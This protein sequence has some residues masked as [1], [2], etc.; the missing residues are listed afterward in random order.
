MSNS[1]RHFTIDRDARGVATVWVDVQGLPVNVFSD[2]V[3]IELAQLV[4]DLERQLPRLAVFRG[5]KKSGFLVGADVRRIHTID[6][7]DDARF[8][9]TAGQQLFQRFAQ[10]PFPTVAV[11]HGACLGGGLEFAL[12]FRFRVARDDS[13]TRLGLPETLLGLCPAWGGTQRLP[14]LVGVR[15]AVRMIL[16][17]SKLT[18][19]QAADAGLVDLAAPPETFEPMLE[20]FVADRLAG[21]P[22]PSR[23]RGLAGRFLDGTAAGRRLVLRAARRAIACRGRHYPALAAALTAIETGLRRPADGPDVERENFVRLLFTDT[24]RRLLDLFFQRER[25]GKAATWVRVETGETRPLGKIAV[26]GGGTMGAGIAQLAALHG[27]PVTIKEINVDLVEAAMKRVASLMDEA[28]KKGIV[29]HNE[30][31]AC[32]RNVVGACDWDA[33]RDADLAIEAV[34]EREE[35]KRD[36]FRELGERLDA[37]AILA[38][39]TSSLTVAR[40]ATPAGHLERVAGLHFFNP[41]QRMQLVEV[42]REPDTDSRTIAALVDFVKRLGKTPVVVADS[43]GFLVNRI[44]FPY[45][46]EA[47][48]LFQEGQPAEL[49]DRSAV[50]FGMPMGPLELLDQVGLDVAADVAASLAG[51]RGGDDSPAPQLLAVMAERGWLGRKSGTGFYRYHRGKRGR[52]ARWPGDA[53]ASRPRPVERASP[54][55]TGLDNFQR[56]L[57]FPMVNEAARCLETSVADAPWV[58]DL[59][60]V[61]GIGFAPFRGGPLR[62]ADSWGIEQVVR[63][64]DDL[65]RGAGERF[66]PCALLREMSREGRRFYPEAA[67][68]SEAAPVPAKSVM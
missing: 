15:T 54:S 10:L 35:V 44:L 53:G 29:G 36:V 45:L 51:L 32:L 67:R 49:I 18:A 46:D 14:R 61:L 3:V 25:A 55:S 48:R 2:D 12:T 11:V 13:S 16:E 21:K 64:L 60:L 58:I 22:L 31:Q 47:M 34:V 28:V 39:N 68:L 20:Q 26:V 52:P 62:A 24:A 1:Y 7:P 38:T 37:G 4:A 6:N 9:I 56:R 59:A 33:L 5:R 8:A 50:L 19:R 30:A 40:V 41:V 65:R 43:P 66:A 23:R 17:G 63:D 57:I 27:F 42:V